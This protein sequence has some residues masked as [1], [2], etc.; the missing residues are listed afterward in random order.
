MTEHSDALDLEGGVFARSDPKSIARS[1][2]RSAEDSRRR[3]SPPFR[4]AMSMITFYENRAGHTLS[5]TQRTKLDRAKAQ[6]RRLYGK[7]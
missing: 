1:L 7:A 5:A 3:R 6:L 2:K 4:S